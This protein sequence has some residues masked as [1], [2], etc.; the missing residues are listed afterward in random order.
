MEIAYGLDVKSHNDKYLQAAERAMDCAREAMVPGAFLVDTF[1]IRS[2]S[3]QSP[4]HSDNDPP[5]KSNMFQ[6][7][8]L[9]QGSEFSRGRAGDYLSLLSMA[10]SST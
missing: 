10:R 9:V 1:P 6:N 7:G 5:P 4:A 2:F 8:S 3:P